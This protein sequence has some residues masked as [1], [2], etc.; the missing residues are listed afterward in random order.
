MSS[1]NADLPPALDAPVLA[2]L[3][4]DPADRPATMAEAWSALRSAMDPEGGNNP[5]VELSS[6]TLGAVNSSRAIAP[7]ARRSFPLTA[8]LAVMG[9]LAIG[10]A[11]MIAA[12]SPTAMG[13]SESG[14]HVGAALGPK[15][16][17][18]TPST[19]PATE[20]PIAQSTALAAPSPHPQAGSAQT[21]IVTPTATSLTAAPK[22]TTAPSSSARVSGDPTAIPAP[23]ARAEPADAAKAP[24]N[25]R[26]APTLGEVD[27]P[28]E[29][30]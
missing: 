5:G 13:A 29:F 6:S 12:S 3:A 17:S 19:D 27:T 4:K 28:D 1:V 10:G 30:R 15:V 21:A 14:A 8:G 20:P 2:M 11:I 22:T 26:A 16:T 23:K 18:A 7:A 9:A 24:Q 25:R